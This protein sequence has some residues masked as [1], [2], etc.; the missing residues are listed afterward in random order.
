M[1][2]RILQGSVTSTSCDKTITIAV[3][4][5]YMHP[6]YKKFVTKTNK[7]TAHDENNECLLGQIV[8]I[9]E[10]RPISKTK[11]WKVLLTK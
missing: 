2:K 9:E 7:F 8:Q 6:M 11:K 5:R 1:S 4:R 3:Q 10:C